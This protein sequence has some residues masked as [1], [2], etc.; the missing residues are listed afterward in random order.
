MTKP[1]RLGQLF[2]RGVAGQEASEAVDFGF[3]DASVYSLCIEVKRSPQREDRVLR[4]DG[5]QPDRHHFLSSNEG[6][7]GEA[8]PSVLFEV[9]GISVVAVVEAASLPKLVIQATG[10]LPVQT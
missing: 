3:R 7:E 9:L 5:A 10:R 1:P 6:G 8:R 2:E 4:T